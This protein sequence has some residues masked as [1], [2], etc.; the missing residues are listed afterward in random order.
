MIS[1]RNSEYLFRPDLAICDP[2]LRPFLP[3][4]NTLPISAK[5]I[6]VSSDSGAPQLNYMGD[7]VLGFHESSMV[8]LE[9]SYLTIQINTNTSVKCVTWIQRG[10]KPFDDSGQGGKERALKA[11]IQF[12]KQSMDMTDQDIADLMSE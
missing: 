3:D 7:P 12:L 9:R 8:Q 11:K 4:P 1:N 10:Y 2:I 6:F 5:A